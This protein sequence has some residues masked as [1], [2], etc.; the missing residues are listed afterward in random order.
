MN[1][2]ITASDKLG[3]QAITKTHISDSALNLARTAILKLQSMDETSADIMALNLINKVQAG[4][5]QVIE[6]TYNG[7]KLTFSI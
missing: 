4:K 6:N 2:T 1:I 7:H 5:P 3:K